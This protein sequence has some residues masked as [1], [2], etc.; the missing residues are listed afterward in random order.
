MNKLFSNIEE[1]ITYSVEDIEFMIEKHISNEEDSYLIIESM[2]ALEAVKE[3]D[4]E[5][6]RATWKE[7]C[8]VSGMEHESNLS[9]EAIVSKKE[10]VTDTLT[11]IWTELYE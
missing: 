10:G 4:L 11:R 6:A 8:S 2:V 7:F 3:D 9:L 5:T 1:K